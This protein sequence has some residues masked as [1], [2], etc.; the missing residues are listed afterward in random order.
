MITNIGKIVIGLMVGMIFLF[1][2]TQTQLNVKPIAKTENPAALLETLRQGLTAARKDR[3]KLLS[4]NW[5]QDAEDSY[6][7]AKAGLDKGSDLSGCFT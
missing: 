1:G 3:V 5:Y 4:P 7:K 2:C 6:A